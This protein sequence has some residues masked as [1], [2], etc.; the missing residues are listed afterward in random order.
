MSFN[1]PFKQWFP[2]C[3]KSD[4]KTL[5]ENRISELERHLADA[6]AE[7]VRANEAVQRLQRQLDDERHRNNEF[8]R[9]RVSS[10][11]TIKDLKRELA[12]VRFQF[13]TAYE[14]FKQMEKLSIDY[15]AV[16]KDKAALQ[17]KLDL[18]DKKE[19]TF[20][21]NASSGNEHF[22]KN[23]Q[24]DNQK[25]KG[26]APKGHIG[27][28]RQCFEEG[29][30]DVKT[31]HVEGSSD[32]FTCCSGS[33]F[34]FV[35]ETKQSVLRVIPMKIIKYVLVKKVY[36][37]DLCGKKITARPDDVLPRSLYSNSV[38]CELLL[39]ILICF[40]TASATAKRFGILTGTIFNI[41]DRMATIFEPCYKKILLELGDSHYLHADE[42]RWRIDGTN[43][44]A[45]LFI[46]DDIVV[47]LFRK[48][49]ASCVPSAIF[50]YRTDIKRLEAAKATDATISSDDN[51]ETKNTER[52][53]ERDKTKRPL[54]VSDRYAVY[55]ML[56]VENQYCYAHLLRD[57][58]GI[59]DGL[60][61]IPEEVHVFCN[62]LAPLLAESMH[63]SADR[64]LS[65]EGYYKKAIELKESILE[66]V[67]ADARD[68]GV[69]A[70]QHIWRSKKESLFKWTEDR[71]IPCE[72]NRAERSLRPVVIAR[73]T[74]FGSQGEKGRRAREILMTVLHTVRQRGIDVR[75][76]IMDALAAKVRDKDADLSELLKPQ[77]P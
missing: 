41:L 56:N 57:L 15:A 74:A 63:L 64:E 11:N 40:G 52:G 70:Y 9:E 77:A 61:D 38:I 71:N 30:E 27:H 45:W 5:L 75:K 24:E 26:G 18:R 43:G 66:I 33:L 67:E 21:R 1:R 16:L 23:A 29:N 4:E 6:G 69:R 8:E 55:N 20:N 25:R 10:R 28:G 35:E 42:T 39:E 19:K 76:F 37:C 72:N 13:D 44:Y 12:D 46:N 60:K 49:R 34:T 32:D 48:T 73:K 53:L 3:Q 2:S 22:K 14:Q 36:K 62:A 59:K 58:E 51:L 54:I 65:D 31:E 47:Y 17:K 7:N 50:G 68:G